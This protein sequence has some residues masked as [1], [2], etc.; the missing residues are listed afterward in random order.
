MMTEW[1]M[2]RATGTFGL[3]DPAEPPSVTIASR[4]AARSTIAGTPVRSCMR[5]RSGLNASSES[6]PPSPCA[7]GCSAQP[8]TAS[9]CAVVTFVPSSCRRRFS[10]STLIEKGSDE[11]AKRWSPGASTA[12]I[13]SS[14]S[15]TRIVV[16]AP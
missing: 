3:I 5:T 2:M 15:S 10:S 6:S 1:S 11:I 7:A 4:I 16:R 9:M 12:K 8:A 13:S 14:R